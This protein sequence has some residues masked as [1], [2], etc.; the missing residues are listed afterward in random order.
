MWQLLISS[1]ILLSLASGVSTRA[2]NQQKVVSQHNVYRKQLKI[3]PLKYSEEC[4]AYAQKWANYLAL[5][6]SGLSHSKT[7]K[8]GENCYW[9]SGQ[10]KEIKVV[11][12]WGDEKSTFNKVKRTYSPG[13]GHYSQMVWR[14]TKFVGAGMAI[15]SDGSEY[16]VCTYYPAGNFIGR[17]AY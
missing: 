7:R 3:A 2:I 5:K 10:A 13:S 17:K 15:A 9:N 14:D 1:S 12:R 4:A 6:N 16:W 11:D 8:Y